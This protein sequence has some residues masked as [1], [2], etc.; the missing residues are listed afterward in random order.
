[1]LK[2]IKGAVKLLNAL[3]PKNREKV[4]EIIAKQDP[5]MAE[6][7]KENLLSLEDLT[8]LSLSMLVE[9]TKSIDLKDLG[10]ALRIADEET[11]K[12][13][14]SQVSK[15]MREDIE[16]G[17]LGKPVPLSKAQEAQQKIL[18]QLRK[19]LENGEIVMGKDEEIV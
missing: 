19:K 2:G 10:L 1:M 16:V 12:H 4:L 18:N 14:L 6:T 8:K 17:L 11:K 3:E 15:G 5:A 7:L 9:F 13:I